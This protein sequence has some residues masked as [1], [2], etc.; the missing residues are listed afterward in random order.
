MNKFCIFFLHPHLLVIDMLSSALFPTDRSCCNDVFHS[1]SPHDMSKE[2][3]LPLS[4]F[5]TQLPPPPPPISVRLSTSPRGSSCSIAT[6]KELWL[7]PRCNIFHY[8]S[9]SFTQGNH[10]PSLHRP[11]PVPTF[12]CYDLL[13]VNL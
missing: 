9:L 1:V 13:F 12:N 3:C 7:A 10:I 4:D 11:M 2:S 5:N 8:L 6:C